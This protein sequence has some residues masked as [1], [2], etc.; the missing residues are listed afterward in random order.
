MPSPLVL[1]LIGSFALAA[2][3]LLLPST[4]SYDPWAWI[5]WGRQ[6]AE[7]ELNTTTG[8]SWKPLPVIFTTLFAPFGEAAPDLWL[9]VARAGAA[10]ALAMCFRIAFRLAGRGL[11]GAVAG[12]LA[13]GGL[14]ISEAYV[15]NAG[16]GY[17]E[18]ILIALALLAVERH[19]DGHREQALVLGFGAALLR[20]EVWPFLGAY[21]LWLWRVKPELRRRMV[22]MGVATPALWFLPE[23][24]GSGDALRASSRAQEAVGNSPALA[25]HPA[26]ELLR[27]AVEQVSAPVHVGVAAAISLMLPAAVRSR[28][29]VIAPVLAGAMLGW[30][31]MVALMTE[32][33]YAG[34]ERY[35]AVPVAIACV[36]AGVGWVGLGLALSRALAR[37]DVRVRALAPVAAAAMLALVV[38]S[39]LPGE[40]EELDR[41]GRQMEYQARL[42]DALPSAIAR[43][44][45]SQRI[46]ACGAPVT[47][48]YQVTAL[49]WHLDAPTEAIQTETAPP[50]FVFRAPATS[51]ARVEPP[52]P[53]R[54]YRL[55]R[56]TRAGEWRVLGACWDPT[57]AR[58]DP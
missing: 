13:T 9:L 47:G 16:L 17:S 8:P 2:V 1:L 4:P 26:Q 18:G 46:L 20:P 52:R 6:I 34:N 37:L 35:L 36:L 27:R 28:R 50:G 31:S 23:L 24:W 38:N 48:P 15:L 14:A 22:A 25:E 21:G 53:T 45:G 56:V 51:S 10:M 55:R 11:T 44:G 57:L 58:K 33:G 54:A 7:L 29:G 40:R 41:D 30:V 5:G 43:A 3:S 42:Y 12:V 32:A 49:A 19:L 39:V